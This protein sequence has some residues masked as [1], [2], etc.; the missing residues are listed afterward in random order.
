MKEAYVLIEIDAHAARPWVIMVSLSDKKSGCLS[1]VLASY[2]TPDDTCS[3]CL[4]NGHEGSHCPEFMDVFPFKTPSQKHGTK[5]IYMTMLNSGF[6]L[7]NK[8]KT[9][10]DMVV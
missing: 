3:L 5:R 10:I 6:D 8:G 7:D 9:I 4:Q 2:L 1:R